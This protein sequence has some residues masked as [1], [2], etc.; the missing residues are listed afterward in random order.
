MDTPANGAKYRTSTAYS[1][2]A[3]AGTFP[4]AHACTPV[5]KENVQIKLSE[6][7]TNDMRV[8]RET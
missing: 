4:N 2:Y 6:K 8:T 7:F 3:L 5:L 1:I